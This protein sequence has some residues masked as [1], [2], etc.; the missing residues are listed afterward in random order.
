MLDTV[1]KGLKEIDKNVQYGICKKE[2]TWDCLLIRKDRIAKSGR[3]NLDYSFYVTISIIREDEIPDGIEHNVEQ[4]MKE[5]GYRRTDTDAKYD[6]TIDA[7]EVV[8]EICTM[9]FVKAS[10]RIC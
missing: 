6:Y 3:S 1:K 7:N 5:L 2:D 4:K 10:K 9:E 8:I